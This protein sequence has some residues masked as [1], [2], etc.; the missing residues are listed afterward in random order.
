MRMPFSSNQINLRNIALICYEFFFR[1]SDEDTDFKNID[2]FLFSND[3][4]AF[5]VKSNKFKK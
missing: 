1:S 2:L 3:E 5:F 4:D